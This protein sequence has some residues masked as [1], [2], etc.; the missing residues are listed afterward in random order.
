MFWQGAQLARLIP[1]DDPGYAGGYVPWRE[2]RY[3]DGGYGVVDGRSLEEGRQFL[4][5]W[6]R[7]IGLKAA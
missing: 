1:N 2:D 5:D 4:E 3:I 7:Q 6:A